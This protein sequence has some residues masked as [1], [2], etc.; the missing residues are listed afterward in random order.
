MKVR[1]SSECCYASESRGTSGFPAP[2]SISA[3]Q[4]ES[5]GI[6]SYAVRRKLAFTAS[7]SRELFASSR[8]LRQTTCSPCLKRPCDLPIDRR[9][10]PLGF[11][12][13]S[14]RQPAASTTRP[15]IP[16]RTLFRPRRFSR[17]RRFAPP[18]AF[19]GLFHPAATS[20][21]CPSGVYPSPRSR[22]GFPR[23][24]HALVPLSAS[25][26]GCPRQPLRPR[27]QG[28]A[29]RSE[30]NVGRDCLGPDRTAPLL[31]FSSPGLP[32]AQ[33]A[34]AFTPA[35]PMTFAAMN[36]PQLVPGVSP[37]RGLACL[38]SGCRP[39]RGS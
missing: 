33:R 26:C 23:P 10:P 39:A 14:R 20:R 16:S 28:L 27:L 22:T 24:R 37:L 32:P 18:P 17:P 34:D 12:P 30:C 35:P 5:N 9:A 13:S 29:P 11:R 15:G 38:E 2:V 1:C 19:A 21:V 4:P 36:P 31:G 6:S 25:A 7:S 3:F 8:V